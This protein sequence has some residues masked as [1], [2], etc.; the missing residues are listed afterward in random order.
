[1]RAEGRL[2]RDFQGYSA[3]RGGAGTIALGVSGIGDVG[4]AYLQ[5]V[6]TLPRYA[7]MLDAGLLPVERGW[8]RSPDDE[9]R[10]AIIGNL[11]CTLRATLAADELDAF[12]PELERLRA[13]ADDGLCVIDGGDIRLTPL[14]RVFVRNVSMAF[15]AYRGHGDARRPVFSRTV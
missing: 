10:R 6:K 7:A 12:A 15:D 4:G 8:V 1:A 14:G 5:N 3:G 2:W 13:L 9:R 11:M